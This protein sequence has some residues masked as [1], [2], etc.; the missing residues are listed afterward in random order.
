MGTTSFTKKSVTDEN[1]TEPGESDVD[2]DMYR[3]Q[4]AEFNNQCCV[5]FW[6][7]EEDQLEQTG[8]QWVQCVCAKDGSMKT[9]MMKY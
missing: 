7:Y 6:T 1:D 8:L 5:C 3:I 4:N 2:V 9:A